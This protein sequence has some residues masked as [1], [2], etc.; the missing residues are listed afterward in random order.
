M[1]N[2]KTPK[3]SEILSFIIV[4]YQKILSPDHGVFKVFFPNGF[5]RFYPSCSEYTRQSLI[6]HGFIN[7]LWLGLGRVARCHPWSEGGL[8]PVPKP[9]NK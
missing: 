9:E 8:D 1:T 7:G 2:K 6:I 5:C 3:V 4:I